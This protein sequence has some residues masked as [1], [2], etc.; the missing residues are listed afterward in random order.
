MTTEAQTPIAVF[1]NS[2]TPLTPSPSTT[3]E[4]RNEIPKQKENTHLLHQNNNP[5]DEN[6]SLSAIETNSS[7]NDDSN[8]EN[9]NNKDLKHHKPH[10]KFNK[11]IV[12]PLKEGTTFIDFV[13][14]QNE[15]NQATKL[16]TQ[17]VNS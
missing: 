6:S 10:L 12:V 8:D 9:E 15:A 4:S 7:D 2:T 14:L 5:N 3:R 13:A 1:T 17:T 16:T 11:R